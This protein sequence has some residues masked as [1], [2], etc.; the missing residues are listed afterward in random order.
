MDAQYS[1]Y[2]KHLP[3]ED[4][5]SVHIVTA[6]TKDEARRLVR[7]AY[8]VHLVPPRGYDLDMFVAIRLH[9]HE[10]EKKSR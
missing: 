10:W 5:H 1:V 6:C 3:N 7:D 4:S 9:A 8:G 2:V